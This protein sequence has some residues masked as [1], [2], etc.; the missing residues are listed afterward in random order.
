MSTVAPGQ[1]SSPNVPHVA[2]DSIPMP[3]VDMGAIPSL[4]PMQALPPAAL[5]PPAQASLPVESVLDPTLIDLTAPHPE[6]PAPQQAIPR[7]ML[8][9]MHQLD[10]SVQGN[11]SAPAS[12]TS[13]SP[14]TPSGVDFG[15]YS[16]NGDKGSMDDLSRPSSMTNLSVYGATKGTLTSNSSE[17][18]VGEDYEEGG[19]PAPKG[20]KSHARKVSYLPSTLCCCR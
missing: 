15:L 20:K 19:V 11:Y 10:V 1:D 14:D 18:G 16:N 7:T 17:S 8:P 9:F 4:P 2:T 13:E 3:L 5:L 12:V 6:P